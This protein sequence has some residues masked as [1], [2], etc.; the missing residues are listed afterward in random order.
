MTYP[1][2]ST[3]EITGTARRYAARYAA[4]LILPLLATSAG[5]GVGNTATVEP[6]LA[7]P[8]AQAKK[9]TVMVDWRMLGGLNY[10]NGEM[11]DT[12]K[13]LDGKLVKVP[14]FIVPLEDYEEEATEF[15]LVPYFG[16]CVHTPPPPPNQIVY[17]KMQ[18]SKKTKVGLFD[19]VWMYGTLK[20]EWTES[21][22][23][24]ASFTMEGLRTAPAGED[25]GAVGH[26]R[27]SGAG[28][29]NEALLRRR[30]SDRKPARLDATVVGHVESPA[31]RH[32]GREDQA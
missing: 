23:G 8:Q 20:V 27:A 17:V 21:V 22:F 7:P 18:N 28:D 3:H 24:P 4:L 10:E 32:L 1:A 13:K 29:L 6:P 9:D 15:L 14:G 12:L 31:P 11:T 26:V 30:F 5:F 25:P 19:A 2:R 16:A